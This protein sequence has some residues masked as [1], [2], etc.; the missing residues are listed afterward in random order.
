MA[1]FVGNYYEVS[2]ENITKYYYAVSQ[3]VAKKLVLQLAIVSIQLKNI[4]QELTSP[5]RCLHLA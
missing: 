4:A 2:G 5:A 3:R 1:T